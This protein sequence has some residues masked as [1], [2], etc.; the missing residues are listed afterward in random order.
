MFK[1][2]KTIESILR[3]GRKLIPISVFDFFQPAYH[4][5]LGAIG[6]VRYGFPSNGLTIIGVTGTKGKSTTVYMIAKALESLGEPVAAIGSLGFKIK[7]KEWPNNLHMTMP[8]RTKLQKFLR[9]AR[10]A[11][12]K[13][14]ILEVTSQG[15]AQGR[16]FGIPVDCAVFTN[17]HPEHIESHGGLRNYINAKK[18][19]FKK[20]GH[21]HVLNGDDK[22]FKEFRSIPAEKTYVY[23]MSKGVINQDE[24][25]LKLQLEGDFNIYNALATLGTIHAYGLDVQKARK[26]IESI[27]SIDGRM[28]FI[29]E[30]QNFD[31]IKH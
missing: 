1:E 27:E 20:A 2:N 5:V 8:G 25:K 9:K 19:L 30:G 7:K 10:D 12:V 23:G 31:F 4:R 15:I 13:H 11:G 14:V 17:L 29:K 18:Q 16:L 3:F 6:A 26:T 22:Y 21:I 28:E 24:L